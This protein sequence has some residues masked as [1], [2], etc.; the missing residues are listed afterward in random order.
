M[1]DNCEYGELV[2]D[3]DGQTY[4]TVKIGD[5]WWM[6]ENLNYETPASYC[7]GDKA[8]KCTKYGRLYT[9]AAAMDSAGTWTSNG[10]DCGYS[11]R[12]SPTYP[13]R[14]VCPS[15]WHLPDSTEWQILFNAVGGKSTAG[16]V[17]K[18]T[19]GWNDYEGKNGNGND[20]FGFSALPVGYMDVDGDYGN[21]GYSTFFW[22]ST[23]YDFTFAYYMELDYY[24]GDTGL[25]RNCKNFGF[26]VRCIQD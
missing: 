1:E 8:S 9:W 18:S 22:S 19:N 3:R 13:V 14:G 11:M 4:K 23:E 12:C 24:G 10:K 5:R 20:A 17:L 21:E 15:G 26:S 16:T 2:D 6:A 25:Y 7:Y